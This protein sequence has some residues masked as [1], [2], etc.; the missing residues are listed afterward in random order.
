MPVE[1]GDIVLFPPYLKHYVVPQE[2]IDSDD[3]MRLTF[4]FN[5]Y[6][7]TTMK[8]YAKNLEVNNE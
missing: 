4:S 6:Q 8:H 7:I 2:K 3:K 5:L 1:D